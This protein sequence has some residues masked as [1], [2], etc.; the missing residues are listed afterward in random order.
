VGF[1]MAILSGPLV[2]DGAKLGFNGDGSVV[3]VF[4]F[5]LHYKIT[6]SPSASAARC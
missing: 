1:G 4:I 5:I 2:G 6:V 3:R